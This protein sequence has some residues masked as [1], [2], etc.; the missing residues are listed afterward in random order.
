MIHSKGF[1]LSNIL[2]VV[3]ILLV[4]ETKVKAEKT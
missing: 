3:C 4:G 2:D 1:V